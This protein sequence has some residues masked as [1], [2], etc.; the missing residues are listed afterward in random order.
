MR[1]TKS[2]DNIE[3]KKIQNAWFRIIDTAD[4]LDD[5]LADYFMW[6]T[7]RI[8]RIQS[9][10]DYLKSKTGEFYTKFN[11]NLQGG[12]KQETKRTNRK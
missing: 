6:D 9:L 8:I 5:L 4:E 7:E 3:H 12:K 2:V 1:N 10:L 11:T